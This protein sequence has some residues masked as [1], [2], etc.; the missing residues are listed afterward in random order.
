[1]LLDDDVANDDEV[2]PPRLTAADIAAP[3]ADGTSPA[4]HQAP[5]LLAAHE[6]HLAGLEEARAVHQLRRADDDPDR[7]SLHLEAAAVHDAA[8]RLHARAAQT[9]DRMADAGDGRRPT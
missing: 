3:F 7:R 5:P 4:S 6:R 8:A 1:V 2:A 9:Y